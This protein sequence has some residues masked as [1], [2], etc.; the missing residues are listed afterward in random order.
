MANAFTRTFGLDTTGWAFEPCGWIQKMIWE[1]FM[2][3]FKAINI[4]KV[5]SL[6]APLLE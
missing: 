4:D 6:A 2:P 1:R 3:S 5:C